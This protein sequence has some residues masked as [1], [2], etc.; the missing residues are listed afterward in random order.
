MSMR[1]IRFSFPLALC[2]AFFGVALFFA[3]CLSVFGAN[4]S[5][6]AVEP[7]DGVRIAWDYSSMRSLAPRG[8]YARMLRLAD[9]SV[10]MVYEDWALH[11]RAGTCGN[12]V[13]IRSYD[14]GVTWS[15]PE[16]IFPYF[17]ATNKETGETALVGMY[18]PEV[19]Q[20]AN[21]DILVATDYRPQKPEVTPYA[22]AVRKSVDNGKTWSDIK[23][24]YEAQPRFH[25][26]C[27]E[28]SF[29]QLPD[30]RVQVYFANEGNFTHS[31]EQEISV[32]T[33]AD[34]GETWGEARRV[35]FRRGHRDGMPVA[36]VIG[37]EIVVAIEDNKEGNFRPYTVRT[38]LEEDWASPVLDDSPGRDYCLTDS[39]ED[40][41]IM[42]AP[43][44]L[45]LPTGE[46]LL[47]Y[48]STQG[49]RPSRVSSQAMNVVVGDKSARRFG[50]VTQPFPLRDDQQSMW[51]SLALWDE[52]TVVAVGEVRLKRTGKPTFIKGYILN[53]M[54]VR[55]KR[56]EEYPLF[57]GAKTE[58]NLRVGLG[59]DRS[60]LYIA[61]KVSDPTPC[62]APSGTE[63]GDGV[64]LLINARNVSSDTPVEGVYKL[65][66][67]SVGDVKLWEGESGRWEPLPAD[68]VKVDVSASSGGY[69]L[70]FT[71]PRKRMDVGEVI[72]I[73]AGISNYTPDGGNVE[74]LVN[75]EADAP[76]TWI[77]ATLGGKKGG[78]RK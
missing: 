35:S 68:G 19:I 51:N 69:E 47:S 7:L 67:S 11:D 3:P 18:N 14:E 59:A 39:L 17:Q 58:A 1:L 62:A 21:G 2:L 72:R 29:L 23:I 56:I 34:N 54:E 63:E 78:R 48:Q 13:I 27:W 73:G 28:P 65:W 25:D 66:C 71:L 32:I 10:V 43:Y 42:G 45:T 46:T 64:F 37:D 9:R 40:N 22:I 4:A 31:G 55:G 24:L 6:N 50:R 33:S 30:G 5:R 74:F 8:G 60:R 61:C 57:V 52:R 41:V 12:T 15:E 70:R 16:V 36:R 20:L 44:L 38:K 75:G 49:G 26:G 76:H 53:D 77:K